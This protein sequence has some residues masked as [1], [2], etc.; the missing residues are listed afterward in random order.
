MSLSPLVSFKSRFVI[1]LLNFPRILRCF[2]ACRQWC[3]VLVTVFL[4]TYRIKIQNSRLKQT[5]LSFLFHW[6]YHNMKQ[7]CEHLLQFLL[8]KDGALSTL[9]AVGKKIKAIFKQNKHLYFISECRFYLWCVF[10]RT[11]VQHGHSPYWYRFDVI[12]TVHRR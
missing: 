10:Q 3:T 2:C 8:Q 4:I 12:L 7:Q 6:Y 11:A 9:I 1:Y 5:S